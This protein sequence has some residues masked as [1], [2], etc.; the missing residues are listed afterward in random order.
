MYILIFKSIK[1]KKA[2]KILGKDKL[3]D[4]LPFRDIPFG[5]NYF[6]ANYLAQEYDLIKTNT[7]ILGAL[8]LKWIKNNYLTITTEEKG[9][10]KTKTTKF[11][12]NEDCTGLITDP[13]EL[14]LWNIINKVAVDN[15]LE[16]NEFKKYCKIHYESLLDLFDK[17]DDSIDENL[18]NNTA[19]ITIV[20]TKKL[21]GT[22]KQYSATPKLNEDARKLAGLKVFFKNFTSLNEKQPIEVKQWREYLIYAQILGMA[23]K[24]AKDFNKFYPDVISDDFYNDIVLINTFSYNSVHAATEAR[25]FAEAAARASSYSSGGGGFS[26]G[27]GG[28]GSFGGGGSGGGFR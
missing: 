18:K 17:I 19:Y 24:V 22:S 28:G 23:D 4:V 13:N 11:I 15:I 5:E 21:F 9:I 10:F 7:N 8:F 6:Y 26:S 1:N 16:D 25:S 2:Y 3:K 27:G 14:E 12:I 20:E